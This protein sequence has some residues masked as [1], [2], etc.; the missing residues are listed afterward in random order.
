M[1]DCYIVL[2]DRWCVAFVNAYGPNE[3]T[4]DYSQDGFCKDL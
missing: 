3:D 4:L 2:W 1:I